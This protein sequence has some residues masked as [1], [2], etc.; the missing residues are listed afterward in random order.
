[1][2]M[3]K[4]AAM[5]APSLKRGA[6]TLSAA[7]MLDFGLQFLLPIALVRLL[8]PTAFADYRLAWLAIG[9]AM[10]VAP[11]ALPRSLF[12]F[13]PRSEPA[14]QAGLVRQTCLLLLATGALAGL[15]L[16][17]WN[18]WLPDSL[19]QMQGA[20]WF[21]PLFLTLWVSASLME[22][23]P[24]ARGDVQGQARVIVLLAFLR[25]L[26]VAGAAASGRVDLVFIALILYAMLKLGGVLHHIARY[27]GWRGAQPPGLLRTQ[28]VYVLPF[29]LASA[30]F[31]LRGQADQWVAAALFAP[32]AFAAFSIG[33]VIN[34]VVSLVRN[35]VSNA[36]APRLSA[37]ESQRD[38][39]GMLRLNRQA[40]LAAAFALAPILMLVAV[41]ARHIVAIIYTDQYLAGAD[42]MRVNAFALLG[43]IV[44]VSTVTVV[45]NQGPFLLLADA[46]LLLVSVAA[47]WT[48][49]H[50][51]GLPGA[52]LG[53]LITLAAGN[54]FSFWRVSRVTGIPLR[55]LQDW[56]V[57]LRILACAIGAAL[58]AVLLDQADLAGPE[59]NP[60]SLAEALLLG[61]VFAFT[62]G[63]LLPAFGLLPYVRAL[64][65]RRP[66][67]SESPTSQD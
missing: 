49:A 25:V 67:P 14:R 60:Y 36:I 6:L 17:P 54:A 12:Y 5:P 46:I 61:L 40:N 28:L 22:Y 4:A 29:G 62:Y 53:N 26:M 52:A 50:V 21:M 3:D 65:L 2:P 33:A 58:P 32:A 38:Q 59:G 9:S 10:A 37:L 15:L 42:V 8:P 66:S 41:L 31:L 57:L 39:A 27:H 34:P 23:L 18:P 63:L 7:N 56:N 47:A 19:R 24:N 1:M 20:S 51:F 11:F 30:L 48:G 64:F 44:E 35:S 55:G 16:G 13:L 43:A 45:L